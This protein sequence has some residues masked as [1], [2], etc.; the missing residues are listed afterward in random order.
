MTKT[1]VPD[2]LSSPF[3]LSPRLLLPFPSSSFR[4][5]SKV[6]VKQLSHNQS[7]QP[8]HLFS[9]PSLP[10][11]PSSPPLPVLDGRDVRCKKY[12][13]QSSHFCSYP[14]SSPFG[15]GCCWQNRLPVLF[16]S[17]L[18]RFAHARLGPSPFPPSFSP[19]FLSY[20]KKCQISVLVI[21]ASCHRAGSRLLPC[22]VSS[23]FSFSW[24][25]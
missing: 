2:A 21:C 12:G 18:M 7:P 10:F 17:A 13:P 11:P 22:S 4:P 6:L 23:L 15:V 3:P 8:F 16:Q 24:A 9:F 14:F 19:S 1:E 20:N 5:R 25:F